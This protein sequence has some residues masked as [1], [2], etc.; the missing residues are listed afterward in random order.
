[1]EKCLFR[2]LKLVIGI[3]LLCLSQVAFAQSHDKQ[4]KPDL[5]EISRQVEAIFRKKPVEII[6]SEA[7]DG[8]YQL[9]S[10]YQLV[11]LSTLPVDH[12]SVNSN[13][14]MQHT[15]LP[16]LSTSG[17]FAYDGVN[18]LYLSHNP[19]MLEKLLA[20]KELIGSK[21]FTP[22]VL[23]EL[24]AMTQIDKN[25]F[26]CKVLNSPQ[27]ILNPTR[28]PSK[29]DSSESTEYKVNNKKFEKVKGMIKKPQW[30]DNRRLEDLVFYCLWGWMHKMDQ[31]LKVVVSF[32]KKDNSFMIDERW[33]EG[34]IY[35]RTPQI[36]Y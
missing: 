6:Y 14:E 17:I 28:H 15:L 35:D 26:Y 31:L 30:N 18:L 25:N 33:I 12:L 1:M 21:K 36:E 4:T 29:G 32:D 7:L 3:Y 2:K 24:I 8:R 9:F 13:F 11:K 27:D 10:P 5:K 20:D 16:S 34:E 19:L 22:Q 23:A